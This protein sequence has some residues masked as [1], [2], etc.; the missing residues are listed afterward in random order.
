VFYDLS[1][2]TTILLFLAIFFAGFVDAVAGGG[3]LIQQPSLLITFS[4]TNTVTVMGTSKTA[5]AFGTSAAALRY[6]T[7]IKTDPKLLLSMVIPAFIGSSL[8]ALLATHV[9]AQNLK[10]AIFFMMVLIF[11]YTFAKPELGKEKVERF[12]P[13]ALKKVGAIAAFVIGFY[14]GLIGPGTGTLLMIVLV[15]VMGFAFIGAS[16]IAKVVNLT[17]NIAAIIVIGIRV[18]IMWKLGIAL[19]IAN[20]LGGLIGS[21]VAVRKGSGFVRTFYLIVTG[22][23][24]LR[25]GYDIFA[26]M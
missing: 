13:G 2:V 17:T 10:S 6:R 9:S 26:S 21:H 12:T 16:A 25:L 7:S 18:P 8:G 1:L 20:L 23:L 4:E 14:D 24:I 11:I 22:L 19:G 3:G 5:A 15:A